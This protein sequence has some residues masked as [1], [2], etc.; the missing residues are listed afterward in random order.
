[1]KRLITFLGTILLV[2]GIVVAQEI[3]PP[4]GGVKTTKANSWSALQ[5]FT[6]GIDLAASQYINWDSTTGS[7]GYGFRDN[8]GTLEFKNSGGAWT[9]FGSLTP[10]VYWSR[11]STVLSPATTT[12][13]VKLFGLQTLQLDAIG[14]TLTNGLYLYN[15]TAA[16]TSQ[17]QYP[18]QI[19]FEGQGWSTNS[20]VSVPIDATMTWYTGHSAQGYGAF[21]IATHNAGQSAG[22]Y[23]PALTITNDGVTNNELVINNGT[24]MANALCATGPSNNACGISTGYI[25]ATNGLLI[26]SK[27]TVK[28][29]TDGKLELFNNAQN[30]G[31]GLD[32]TSDGVLAIR[33]TAEN[34]AASITASVFETM[35]ALITA[36]DGGSTASFTTNM[37]GSTDGPTTAT[38]D[39]WVK[40]KDSSG[41]TIWVPEWK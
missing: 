16:T 21:Q 40:M 22:T 13:T 24:I 32:F 8:S 34:A 5:T 11:T 12:D 23:A 14:S 19:H 33:N 35:T 6:N 1:M 4:S 18:A 3:T 15:S 29:G 41:A 10:S 39:G 36:T 17:L 30:A 37:V 9:T 25:V 2:G 20:S 26:A 28:S 7:S 27:S 38:Q 31:I